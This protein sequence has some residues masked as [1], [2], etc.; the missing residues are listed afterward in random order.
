MRILFVSPRQCW[1]PLS[2]AKLRE[3]YLAR[4]LDRY[5]ELTHVFFSQAGP[6]ASEGLPWKAVPVP[7]PRFYTPA[8]IAR[9]IFGRWPLPVV[10]YT[11]DPMK[12]ALA[13][14][15]DGQPFDLIHLDSIHMTAYEPILR[16]AGAPIVYDWH[17]IESEA[18]RRY[19]ANVP[20]LAHKLYASITA[21][22]LSNLENQ[23]LRAGFGQVVCSE[24]ERTTLLDT[25]PKARIA[26]IENGVDTEFFRGAAH[27]D[28]RYRILFVGSM[29]YHANVE[30]AVAFARRVWP[31]IRERFPGWRL[32][33]A[34]SDPAP[35]VVALG[36]EAN[37]EVTGTV[38]D[39]RPFYQE[40]IAAIVPIRTGGGTRLKILE[41]MAAGAPV[42]S[43]SLGAEGLAV[44]PGTDILIAD[45]DEDWLPQLSALST[46]GD[47]WN[48]L[49]EAG[50][51]LVTARYDWETLGQALYET[52]CRWLGRPQ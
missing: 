2:G 15:V 47:L 33:L 28:G 37:V 27:R 9:G 49:S 11:S 48:R 25:A 32:T 26:V 17:N 14:L 46:Q 41:A 19:G 21:R 22:R 7:V 20:S 29:R 39:L 34:G 23:V 40:A 38:A 13:S 42:V 5:A 1:P 8:K 44:S 4:A 43:T 6:P 50:R 45:R 52:Y 10:N 24:R 51:R 31:G 35:A 36:G 3:Y 30:A 16:R 18:M 12:A